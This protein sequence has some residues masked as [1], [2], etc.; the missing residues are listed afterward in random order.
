MEAIDSYEKKYSYYKKLLSLTYREAIQFL[1]EKHGEVIDNYYKEK[2]YN[3]FLDGKIKKITHGKYT[4][5]KEGLYC[6]HTLENEH[7]NIS[8]TK[9]IA[10]YKYPFEYH[11]K[12]NLVYCDLIEHLILHALITEETNGDRGFRGLVVFLIPMVKDWYIDGI[13]PIPIWKQLCRERAYLPKV[14]TKKLLMDVDELLKDVDAYKLILEEVRKKE[15][16][17]INHEKKIQKMIREA[18]LNQEARIRSIMQS[19]NISQEEAE[20]N[21]YLIDREFLLYSYKQVI[22]NF[23]ADKTLSRAKVLSD[24]SYFLDLDEYHTPHHYVSDE[25]KSKN[26]NI[27][28]ENLVKETETIIEKLKYKLKTAKYYKFENTC[29]SK[30]L[31]KK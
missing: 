22:Y 15:L 27:I 5:T 18:K 6:H 20:K 7:E 8:N 29:D 19:L 1:L 11:K 16:D 23:K 30:E 25:F 2:S 26:I 31:N 3:S 14:Y 28:K 10:Q 13:E 24:Y 17:K 9:F 4:K 12:E 21:E